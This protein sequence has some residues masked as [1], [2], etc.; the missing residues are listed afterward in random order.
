MDEQRREAF[1]VALQEALED[2]AKIDATISFLTGKLGIQA[3]VL[4]EIGMGEASEAREVGPLNVT[5][6]EFYGL[7]S[8]QAARAVLE[9]AGRSRPMKTDELFTMISRGGVTLTGKYA[10]PTFHRTLSKDPTFH[11][12]GP[13]RWGLREWYGNVPARKPSRTN[14]E[15]TG[16][17]IATDDGDPGDMET[18]GGDS[19]GP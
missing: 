14:R 3:T 10:K 18:N 11:R 17:E 5:E 12:V 6:G 16:D 4:T 1:K 19:M 8:T 13:G 7:S 9:R 2:R 15:A